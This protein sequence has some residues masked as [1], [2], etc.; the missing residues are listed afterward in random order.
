MSVKKSAERESL[1]KFVRRV[2]TEKKL[3]LAEVERQS[4]RFGERIAA[5]YV[6]RIENE[7]KTRL[8]ADRLTALAHGL[9][10]PEDELF[11]VARGRMPANKEDANELK[12]MIKFRELPPERQE[13]ILRIVDSLHRE[14]AVKQPDVNDAKKKSG[15]KVA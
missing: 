8:S 1:A 12:L 7:I 10:V 9:G 5:S 6:N 14:H 11:A 4:G 13:D 2:R 15:W 3:S